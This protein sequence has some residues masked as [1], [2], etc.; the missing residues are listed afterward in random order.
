MTEKK[1]PQISGQ[2]HN[3][4]R[5]FE[6]SNIMTEWKTIPFMEYFRIIYATTR[7]EFVILTISVYE[8]GSARC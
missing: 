3:P 2:Y 8:S 6:P 1:L 7:Q 5:I 4:E